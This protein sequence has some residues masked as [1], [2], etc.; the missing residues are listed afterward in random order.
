MHEAYTVTFAEQPSF[1]S[2]DICEDKWHHHLV[3]Q[4]NI[5][6]MI[7]PRVRWILLSFVAARWLVLSFFT[8]NCASSIVYFCHS[9]QHSIL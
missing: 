7:L 5:H 3:A 6:D 9:V 1:P 8:T 4:I 2:L